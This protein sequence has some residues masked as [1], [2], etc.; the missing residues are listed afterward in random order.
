MPSLQVEIALVCAFV[1]VV[2]I[3]QL[4]SNVLWSLN[5]RNRQVNR[6]L[7]MLQS[8]ME[9]DQ[10]FSALIR[11]SAAPIVGGQSL[12]TTF[13]RIETFCRQA[14]MTITPLRL[15]LITAAIAAGLW[16]TSMIFL[17]GNDGASMVI[18]GVG[19]FVGA[20]GVAIIG[21]GF[22]VANRRTARMKK[23]EE[24]MP[25][26]LDVINRAVRAGHPVISAVQLAA[27]ELGDPIGS[28]F[29]LIVD[30]TTYGAEFREA[31]TSFAHRTGSADAHFFAVSVGIQSETGGN[32][33][34]I[35][36]GLATV[37]RGRATL[38]KRIKALASE[39][40]ASA[41]ILSVLPLFLVSAMFLLQ[42]T[43]YTSKFNDPVFWPT[44]GVIMVLYFIG[45]LMLR[46]IV[47]FKF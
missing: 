25:L 11:K 38:A 41:M 43:F 7:T 23:L 39:G 15:G 17:H 42:P 6:R 27:D 1:A 31:L 29:G 19:S 18:N 12:Q 16:I 40:R 5:Q 8:G 45:Q 28:E 3:A 9:P 26:A 47:N 24:Q 33:A 10:V 30:E 32:L 4:V 21:V 14:G 22:W 44:A 46:R 34:D 2:L 36:D 20:C 13:D 37:I 35:L